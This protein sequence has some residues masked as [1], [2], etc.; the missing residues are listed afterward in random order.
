MLSRYNK[1]CST[2]TKGW[3]VN[4]HFRYLLHAVSS[5]SSSPFWPTTGVFPLCVS[6]F[7]CMDAAFP[8]D[9][10][11]F[12]TWKV[13][14]GRGSSKSSWLPKLNWEEEEAHWEWGKRTCTTP[15]I[16]V[17][18]ISAGREFRKSQKV[19]FY[20][21]LQVGR[22]CRRRS[23]ALPVCVRLRLLLV[24][25]VDGWCDIRGGQGC[26]FFLPFLFAPPVHAVHPLA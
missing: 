19:S 23:H 15:V 11:S 17:T 8:V 4:G 25:L 1:Y 21:W 16:S 12:S 2:V 22:L 5:P 20:L 13:V 9:K 6:A 14:S 24:Y 10:C 3:A 7:I 26:L 18:T